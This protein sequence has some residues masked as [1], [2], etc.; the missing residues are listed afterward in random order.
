MYTY[1][2]ILVTIEYYAFTLSL[3]KRVANRRFTGLVPILVVLNDGSSLHVNI[4]QVE[5]LSGVQ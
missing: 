4:E 3:A 1:S 2:L 5:L